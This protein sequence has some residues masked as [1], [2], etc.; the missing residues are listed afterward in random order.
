MKIN[1]LL[2]AAFLIATLVTI[3]VAAQ[4]ANRCPE[5]PGKPTVQPNSGILEDDPR[6]PVEKIAKDLGVT[7][8]QFRTAF[9]KVH[10]A[11]RGERPT[12]AQREANRQTLSKAL[13]VAPEKLDAVM[14]KYRPEGNGKEWGVR[15]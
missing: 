6:R 3:R 9:K 13:G 14:D 11:P 4:S 2:T 12:E 8:E 7:P 5:L 15:R 1:G 10:P